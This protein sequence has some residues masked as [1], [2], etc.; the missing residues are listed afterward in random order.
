MSLNTSPPTRPSQLTEIR[1]WML[2]A[3]AV[4]AHTVGIVW[5]AATLSADFKSLKDFMVIQQQQFGDHEQRLRRLE[6][7]PGKDK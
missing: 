2:A 3:I 5:W 4:F 6:L 1:A 7:Q